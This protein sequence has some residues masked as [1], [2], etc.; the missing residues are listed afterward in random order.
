MGPV[1]SKTPRVTQ[2]QAQSEPVL[3]LRH[4]GRVQDKDMPI[5]SPGMEMAKPGTPDLRRRKHSVVL[6]S[7]PDTPGPENPPQTVR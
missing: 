3:D 1:A 2:E 5:E 7:T 4:V 6:P